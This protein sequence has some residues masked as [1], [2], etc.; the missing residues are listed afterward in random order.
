MARRQ[1]LLAG[2][3]MPLALCVLLAVVQ[4]SQQHGLM[5]RHSSTISWI[6][7][8]LP[9]HAFAASAQRAAPDSH[10]PRRCAP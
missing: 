7:L 2:V 10:L 8:R 1:G 5:V 6:D 4:R 3:G 9:P